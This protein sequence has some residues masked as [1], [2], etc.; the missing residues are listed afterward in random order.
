MCTATHFSSARAQDKKELADM[1][2]EIQRLVDGS[3]DSGQR[4]VRQAAVGAAQGRGFDPTETSPHR[5]GDKLE[6]GSMIAGKYRIS[7]QLKRGAMGTV[8]AAVHTGT[9]RSVAVKVLHPMFATMP[10]AVA[11]F[12]REARATSEVSHEGIAHVVDSG[13][14]DEIHYLVMERLSGR[15]LAAMLEQEGGVTLSRA[16]A[17]IADVAAALSAAH[18]VGV[19]HR[20]VSPRN[21][22]IVSKNRSDSRNDRVMV[23][24]FGIAYVAEV[25][26]DRLTKPGMPIGTPEY[27]APEQAGGQSTD[28]SVDMYA[29]GA[30]FYEMICGRSPDAGRSVVEVMER[31]RGP[32]PELVSASAEP[33][34]GIPPR[35]EQLIRS[36][37][38]RDPKDRPASMR[39][40]VAVLRAPRTTGEL[41]VAG[42]GGG[43]APAGRRGYWIALAVVMCLCFVGVFVW[44]LRRPERSFDPGRA[45]TLATKHDVPETDGGTPRDALADIAPRHDTK[46]AM[47]VVTSKTGET[48]RTG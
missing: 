43:D 21:I 19:I 18:E 23:L 28:A 35:I 32:T 36:M 44:R 9:S 30:I 25:S 40:I 3:S 29:L 34:D 4:G 45:T 10:D 11:R 41:P 6:A 20:D 33:I 42:S 12:R 8:Y 46:H 27:M 37:L 15:T 47:H 7:D 16:K 13:V 17:I 2:I 1:A 5:R 24:D 39:D 26:G 48:I 14:D 38:A 22:F 31:K